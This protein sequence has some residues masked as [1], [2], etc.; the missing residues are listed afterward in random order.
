MMIAE[1]E[2]ISENKV[3]VNSKSNQILNVA[4]MEIIE[5]G[6]NVAEIIPNEMGNMIVLL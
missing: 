2:I 1:M 6:G 3:Q 4:I 5:N